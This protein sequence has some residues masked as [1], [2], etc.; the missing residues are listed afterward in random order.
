MNDLELDHP[1]LYADTYEKAMAMTHELT[2]LDL[3]M[4]DMLKG[5]PDLPWVP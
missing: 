3:D 4:T 5:T 2:G 1:E